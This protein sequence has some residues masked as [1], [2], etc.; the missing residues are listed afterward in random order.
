VQI[1]QREIAMNASMQI[2]MR[3]DQITINLICFVI[4]NGSECMHLI[5][6]GLQVIIDVNEAE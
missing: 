3:S 5:I 1:V 4:L 2:F 6:G